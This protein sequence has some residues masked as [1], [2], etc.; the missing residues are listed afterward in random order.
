LKKHDVREISKKIDEMKFKDL[1]LSERG[2]M[3]YFIEVKTKKYTN[4]VTWS[5]IADVPEVK[6][7]Y[8]TLV[9]TL[10]QEK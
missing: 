2:N 5:D 10:T 4:R 7:F 6:E 1:K 9:K 8:K 3:T